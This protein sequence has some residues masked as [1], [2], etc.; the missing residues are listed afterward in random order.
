MVQADTFK[1]LECSV[2]MDHSSL[3]N[4]NRYRLTPAIASL[5]IVLAIII[6]LIT[7][8]IR[9]YP[10]DMNG[11]VVWSN[12]L[13]QHGPAEFYGSSGFHVV[14]A[15]FYQY[16]LWLTG[17]L[18]QAFS[19][20]LLT[21]VYLIKLWS[22]IFELLGA[23]LIWTIG[24]KNKAP[25]EGFILSIFYFL[26]PAI[27]INSSVWGQF[28]SI[29]ATMLI[30][31]I[32][33]FINKKNNLAVLLFLVSVL[34]K[35]QSALLL[36]VVLYLYFKDFR[37]DRKSI[38][39]GII[40]LFSGLLVYYAIVIPFY[41]PTH[42]AGKI[43]R[44]L[45]QIYWLFDLYFTSVKDYPYGTA[46][47]FNVWFLL[48]GQI[49][50]DHLPFLGLNYMTWGMILLILGLIFST[51]C[52]I[53]KKASVHSIFYSSFL[54]LFTA[55]FFMTKMHERYLLPAIIFITISALFEKRHIIT[56]ILISICVYINQLY[57]YMISFDGVYWLSRWDTIGI[58]IS[59]VTLFA[60]ILALY[61]GYTLFIKPQKSKEKR[62][63]VNIRGEQNELKNN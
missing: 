43:P 27:F 51:V 35:P 4:E 60:Y 31:V 49:Q 3:R 9:P 59:A 14:Y 24:K 44:F 38:L 22:V 26:N 40:L 53:K 34:T 50:H 13:A 61:N 20:P 1:S 19:L 2:I 58:I 32:L 6:R 54:V 21:H 45:D 36:P 5:I 42:L 47:A 62:L 39:R 55:F 29:T 16:F 7:T 57:L 18:V 46:N 15:P 23:F 10:I 12:Y 33:L 56:L 52:L 30:G 37:L 8:L 17:E 11:Y 48:G 28:D 25:I 63:K 41:I